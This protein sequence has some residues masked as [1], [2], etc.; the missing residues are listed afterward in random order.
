MG[1]KLL[2]TSQALVNFL[3]N[4]F[5]ERDGVERRFFAGCA[6]I[7]GHGIVAGLGQALQQTP[8]FPYFQGR[9]E[10]AIVHMAVGYAKMRDRLGAF[11][12]TASIGPGSTNL[13]TGAAGATVNRLPVLL[14]PSDI[15][16]RRTASPHLQAMESE[17]T[18]DISVNDSLKPV[19]RYWDRIYRPEQL[20]AALMH[21][22]RVLTSP[23]DTGAVTLCL[24]QDVQ[25]EAYAYPEELFA[26]RVWAIPRT[27]PD[28]TM[29]ERAA[30]W[31]RHSK[32][33]LIVAGGGCIYSEATG[34]LSE[35]A[36]STGIPVAE[37]H[38]GKGS[39]HYEH[40]QSV[41]TLGVTGALGGNRLARDADLVLGIGTRYTD[42]TTSSKTAFQHPD[43]RF[44]N[45]NVAEVDA[46]KHNALPLVA[47]ARATLEVLS[48]ALAG[49]SVSSEYSA[50]VAGLRRQWDA[51][52]DGYYHPER[53]GAITQAEVIGAVNE[54][55]GPRDVVVCASGSLTGDLHKLW[56]TRDPKGYQ[57]EHGYS[58][59]GYE[60]AGGLGAKMAA[61]DRE[62]YV[63]MGDGCYLM[64]SS[65]ILTS[66]QEG[67][68]LTIV[69]LDNHG[70]A[71]INR[72]SHATGSEGFGTEF[73]SR[74]EDGQLSGD[75][76]DIDFAASAR[77]LGANA[78]KVDGLEQLRQ[79]LA[80]AKES[81]R[82]TIIVVEPDP[83]RAVSNYG[84]WWDVPMS[85]VSDRAAVTGARE[86]YEEML[87]KQRYYL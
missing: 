13:V 9:N 56:R 37:T 18:L 26:K 3:K 74:G 30:E 41:G 57:M 84:S 86:E 38:A 23:A 20:I 40:P 65:E 60:I 21:A 47:D 78:V 46:H 81:A 32:T 55:S 50:R 16:A 53:G 59:M 70:F 85:E 17:H 71:S 25:A 8:D 43:V 22:M 62:V 5:V 10:Q 36:R 45:V 52:V 79:A 76:L 48:A 33:P 27:P 1:T 12:C 44:I 64:M 34:A 67:I 39:L 6:G 73:R 83:S 87:K 80:E 63:L 28:G 4:Q 35:F 82:T 11:A 29:L 49:F 77:A 31:L 69:L 72:L 66:L 68:K 61:P 14:L 51:E 2:T 54:F 75:Y 19:S 24:P 7:F 58:T 42:F 15:F